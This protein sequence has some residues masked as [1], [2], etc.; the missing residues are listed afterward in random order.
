MEHLRGSILDGQ[1]VILDDVDVSLKVT[2][3]HQ[4][5]VEWHGCFAVPSDRCELTL[6]RTY[7]LVVT[8]GRSGDIEVAG[9]QSNVS[10]VMFTGSGLFS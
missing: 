1:D 8:D 10:R 7:R 2:E 9:R 6:K 5:R 3:D 4:G